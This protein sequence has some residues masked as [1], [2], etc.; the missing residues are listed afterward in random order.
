[1][2]FAQQHLNNQKYIKKKYN[3]IQCITRLIKN[4]ILR[5]R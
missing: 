1:M 3:K 2:H 5:S 4:H